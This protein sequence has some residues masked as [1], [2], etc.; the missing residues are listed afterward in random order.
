MDSS[1]IYENEGEKTHEKRGRGQDEQTDTNSRAHQNSQSQSSHDIA[2]TQIS[3]PDSRF[4]RARETREI[5]R[6]YLHPQL[7]RHG[8]Q[9]LS[10]TGNRWRCSSWASCSELD[11]CAVA[12]T[13]SSMQ[14]SKHA[15]NDARASR[16]FDF[17]SG[18]ISW[19]I[20]PSDKITSIIANSQ[21]NA[22][23]RGSVRISIILHILISACLYWFVCHYYHT[24]LVTCCS[25][26][27]LTIT[28]VSGGVW[29]IPN[30]FKIEFKTCSFCCWKPFE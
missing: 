9:Q 10:P 19:Y 26:F 30:K 1:G 17:A 2:T 6:P 12:R 15:G 20:R 23:S 25:Q 29:G 16:R 11:G 3:S 27:T 5:F 4:A 14:P 8:R 13:K 24:Y 21:I 28:L 7:I 22:W 18:W